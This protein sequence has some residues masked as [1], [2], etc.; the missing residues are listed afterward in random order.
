MKAADSR[1]DLGQKMQSFL[2][3]YDL[4]ITPTLPNVAFAV[5][6]NTETADQ[7]H[8]MQWTPF[9]Y[10]FNL[11]QQPALSIP[12]GEVDGLPVGLQIVADRGKDLLAINAA[13]HIEQALPTVFLSTPRRFS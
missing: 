8:W 9:S 3:E 12:C 5:G 11:T 13:M 6:Q 4:L 2:S 1:A 10:P 7:E